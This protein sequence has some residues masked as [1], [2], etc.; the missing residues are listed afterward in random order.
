MV[1]NAEKI[2]KEL[3]L[4]EIL[5]KPFPTQEIKYRKGFNGKQLA[6]IETVNYI[7]R[8][9]QA[10]KYQWSWEVIDYK[11]E[12]KQVYCKG[13]LT[14]IINGTPVIK[15]GF[16]GKIRTGGE[17]GDDLKSASSDA[18]KKA[19]SLLGIGLHLYKGK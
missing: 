19:S 1:I 2:L 8:L 6:Y 9:N 16:G 13:K 7:E 18:L 5:T 4:E 12:E 10:F 17:L 15:E 3:T 14:V 11:V